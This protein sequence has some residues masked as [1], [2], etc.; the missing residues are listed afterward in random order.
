MAAP[1]TPAVPIRA[2]RAPHEIGLDFVRHVRGEEA[3]PEETALLQKAFECCPEDPDL[4]AERVV[5]VQTRRDAAGSAQIVV[6]DHGGGLPAGAEDQIFEPFVTTKP[7]GMGMGL[8]VARSLVDDH[9][10]RIRA[11]NHPAGGAV[12]TIS[13]PIASDRPGASAG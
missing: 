9:G 11:A 12:L 3:S 7:T 10:G 5:S 13:L 2:G 8:A 6:H 1:D 4:L